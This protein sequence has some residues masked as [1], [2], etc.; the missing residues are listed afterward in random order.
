MSKISYVIQWTIN[1]GEVENFKAMASGFVSGVKENEPGTLEYQW[2]IGEDGK[3]CLLEETF[4]S[5]ETL[6]THLGNVG[7]SLPSILAIAPIT[8]LEVRGNPSA[9]A[10][11]ALAGLGATHF[12]QFAGFDR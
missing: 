1:D 3:H 9:E 7:P 2:Y 4:E 5:S 12:V 8:R 10:R 6:L 11:D